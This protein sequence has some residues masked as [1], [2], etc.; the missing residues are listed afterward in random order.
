M[1]EQE[2][3]SEV[4]DRVTQIKIVKLEVELRINLAGFLGCLIGALGS[5][6]VVLQILPINSVVEPIN[7]G[8]LFFFAIMGLS[9]GY[10][11]YL[12][13][14]KLKTTRKNINELT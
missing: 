8:I 14:E 1:A 2:R 9:C 13:R 3:S 4:M 6:I 5:I 7:S 11:T 12:F 10:G